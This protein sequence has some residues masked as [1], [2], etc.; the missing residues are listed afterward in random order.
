MATRWGDERITVK[1]LEVMA[2][3]ADKNQIL[4]RARSLAGARA[5]SWCG[6]RR[7]RSARP[8]HSRR[9]REREAGNDGRYTT[10]KNPGAEPGKSAIDTGAFGVKVKKRLLREA[11]LMYAAQQAAGYALDQDAARR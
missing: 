11:V 10:L 3:D 6:R 8:R 7:L 2:V 4:V 1:N 9:R 5:S